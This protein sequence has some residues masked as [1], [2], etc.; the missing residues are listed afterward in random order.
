MTAPEIMNGAAVNMFEQHR[1]RLREVYSNAVSDIMDRCLGELLLPAEQLTVLIDAAQFT[2]FLFAI[3][4]VERQ[5]GDP[6]DRKA[7]MQ[8]YR[9]LHVPIDKE[10][11]R[12]LM[13][14]V[15]ALKSGATT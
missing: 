10:V 11:P 3:K 6:K 7:I 1:G 4:I 13:E 14:F 8:A 9:A 12:M 5:G 15:D 2:V